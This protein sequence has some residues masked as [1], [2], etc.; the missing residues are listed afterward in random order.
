MEGGGEETKVEA[1]A[2]EGERAEEVA[3]GE[4]MEDGVVKNFSYM[5]ET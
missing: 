4:M 5:R 1:D 2:Y 3:M